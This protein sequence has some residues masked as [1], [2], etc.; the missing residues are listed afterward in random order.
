MNRYSLGKA[1]SF[2]EDC[3]IWV[4]WNVLDVAVFNRRIKIYYCCC[5]NAYERVCLKAPTM[6]VYLTVLNNIMALTRYPNVIHRQMLDI[7][8]NQL[9]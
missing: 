6:S 7:H 8:S 9:T 3:V 4:M 2:Y 1:N 5:L